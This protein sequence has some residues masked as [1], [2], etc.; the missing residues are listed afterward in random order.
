MAYDAGRVEVGVG[1]KLDRASWQ[2]VDARSKKVSSSEKAEVTVGFQ[3]DR[4][5]L[6]RAYQL[7]RKW[8]QERA[9]AKLGFTI[10]RGQ[11][12]EHLRMVR[13]AGRR[14]AKAS[15]G[16]KIDRANLRQF[17]A[18]MAH[19]IRRV[20]RDLTVDVK[21]RLDESASRSTTAL[22]DNERSGRPEQRGLQGPRWLAA[23]VVQRARG[24]DQG[25]SRLSVSLG[26][27][28]GRLQ[29]L[30]NAAVVL[31]PI[32]ASLAGVMVALGSS[33]LS[34]AGRRCRRLAARSGPRWSRQEF[35]AS[36]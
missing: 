31:A 32:L 18:Q 30:G 11:Y 5:Q 27:L 33:F 4:R 35:S 28:S 12:N 17:E 25:V 8:R 20:S 3:I 10:L 34:A 13:T 1:A 23:G 36:A 19:A 9:D 29:Y 2:K 26:P 15:L 6:D 22:A 7:L 16:F 24:P 14:E 21:V